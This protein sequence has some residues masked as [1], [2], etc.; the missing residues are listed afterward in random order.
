MIINDF[1][2]RLLT[3]QQDGQQAISGPSNWV[4]EPVLQVET[5]LHKIVADLDVSIGP[6]SAPINQGR[7]HFFV[8]SPGNGKSAGAGLLARLLREKGHAIRVQGTQESLDDLGPSDVPYLLEV[9]APGKNY[10]YLLI[11]QD[12]SVLPDPYDPEGDPGTALENLLIEAVT[13]GVSVVVCTNR[14]VVERVF[15]R[16][17]LEPEHSK[18]G[19]F[20]AIKVA[21]GRDSSTVIDV[22]FTSKKRVF[23]SVRVTATSLDR[24]SLML[25]DNTLDQLLRKATESEKWSACDSCPSRPLC[26]FKSNRDWLANTELRRKVVALLLNAE[27]YDGQVIVL[28]EALAVVS[29]VLAGCP[30]DYESGKPCLWVHQKVNSGDL[31]SL[32]SRRIYMVLFS[33][34]SPFGIEPDDRDRKLQLKALRAVH[35]STDPIAGISSKA[36]PAVFDAKN[37]PSTDVGAQRLLGRARTLA[38]LDAFSDSLPQS[39]ADQWDESWLALQAGGEWISQIETDCFKCWTEMQKAAATCSDTIPSSYRWLT[40]WMTAFTVRAGA[41]VEGVTTF[42]EDL[43]AL[44]SVLGI[45]GKPNKEQLGVVTKIEKTLRQ[46][47]DQSGKGISISPAASLRG[48][49]KDNELKPYLL[50]GVAG[51]GANAVE[52]RFGKSSRVKIALETKA[53]AWLKRRAE[54]AMAL[55]T[56]PSAY[57]E[58]AQDAML[59]VAVTSG[60]DTS[61]EI[62]IYIDTLDGVAIKITRSHGVIDVEYC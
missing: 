33:A 10:P 27:L 45:T 40:R 46:I 34:Y 54:R 15:A 9:C 51:D 3:L 37:W 17:Y 32:A 22:P 16:R 49:W 29:L 23:D 44:V 62:E 38:M 14:G 4:T 2:E 18:A 58:T 56:F 28:R 11:A 21:V 20:K 24:R 8:G 59:R 19:W 31:F 7:W 48:E 25:A 12:A 13:R 52:F 30:H 42:N 6:D 39:F 43:E 53:F 26:P 41:L 55:A 35:S 36:M 60:Y 5:S 50:N 47:L 61:D 57:L 1:L